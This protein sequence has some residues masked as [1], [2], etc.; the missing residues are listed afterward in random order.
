M[1]ER[2]VVGAPS[3]QQSS[4]RIGG[5]CICSS[6]RTE[7][8]VFSSLMRIRRGEEK[9]KLLR[10]ANDQALCFMVFNFIVVYLLFCLRVC[11]F[12]IYICLVCILLVPF[13][14]LGQEP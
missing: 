4:A 8:I 5:G 11:F 2:V 9:W 14:N 13:K 3:P 12:V 10:N 7:E 6:D 1:C